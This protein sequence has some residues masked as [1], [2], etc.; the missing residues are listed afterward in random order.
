MAEYAALEK[1]VY[2]T[3]QAQPFT[4]IDTKLAWAQRELME[5]EAAQV[6]LK[7]KVLYVCSGD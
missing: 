4:R 7:V 3:I 5:E 1:E 6:A 2:D